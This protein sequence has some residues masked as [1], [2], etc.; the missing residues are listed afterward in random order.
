MMITRNNKEID[1]R[2]HLPEFIY[3][4]EPENENILVV[5]SKEH[6]LIVVTAEDLFK[7][8][9][10]KTATWGL[11]RW[12]KILGL[13]PAVN[14]TYEQRRNRILLK[15]QKCRTSTVKFMEELVRRYVSDDSEI[16]II[17]YNED[18]AFKVVQTN[19]Y[20]IYMPDLREAIETYKPAHLGYWFEHI[21][22]NLNDDVDVPVTQIDLGVNLEY[23]DVIPYGLNHPLLRGKLNRGGFFTRRANDIRGYLKRGQIFAPIRTPSENLNIDEI[24]FNLQFS[25]EEKIQTEKQRSYDAKRGDLKRGAVYPSPV[26]MKLNSSINLK[27]E[28]KLT[29]INESSQM[30][31][32]YTPIRNALTRGRF[33][34][35]SQI[36]GGNVEIIRPPKRGQLK[37][38]CFS[39][40][41]SI[42]ARW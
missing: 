30:Q 18:Y 2:Q 5:E 14:D 17:E 27:Y 39:R 41:S 31:V 15:L 40:N 23:E 34:R 1:L 12:E 21:I 9:F 38:S 35:G 36:Y 26:D 24:G 28:D 16:K 3:L 10:V 37:R 33:K 22:N 32:E 11:M 29:N 6:E 4:N 25:F 19:G 20:V 7:Q 8:L 42:I 13:Y